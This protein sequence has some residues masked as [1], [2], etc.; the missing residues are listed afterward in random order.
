MS[1]PQ[2]SFTSPL[3][4]G[5][6]T[7]KFGALKTLL[8]IGLTPQLI[9]M[10]RSLSHFTSLYTSEAMFAHWNHTSPP[11][12]PSI[13]NSFLDLHDISNTEIREAIVSF[14]P[15][16]A[17][18]PDG[19][20]LVFFQKYWNIVA[21]LLCL[22]PKTSKPETVCQLRPIGLC[23][24]LYKAITKILVRHLKLHLNDLIH[25][26]QASFILNRKASDNIILTQEI[27]FLIT[28]SKSKKGTMAIKI[29]LEKA[30]DRL[31]WGFI[32]QTPIYFKFPPDWISL[33]M[34]YIFS[35]NLSILLNG[36][37]LD[38]FHSSRGI[39]QGDPL[40]PYIFILC[41]KYL[42]WHIQEEVSSSNWK[43]IKAFINGPTFTDLFFC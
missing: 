37:C 19:F 26:F 5:D 24:T 23:N 2:N 6:T 33:I 17:L 15:L 36:D 3:S 20:H 43:G 9:F 25:P 38:P 35:S 10:I 40:S 30:F 18:G 22:I 32:R 42:A 7:I 11:H 41:M 31:E 16:K 39:R 34:S 8:E 21:T 1:L 4:V 14:K 13:P 28:T 29:D 12:F 27:I